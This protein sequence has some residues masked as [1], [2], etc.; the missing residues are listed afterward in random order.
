MQ[1][2]F[3]MSQLNASQATTPLQHPMTSTS[4]RL[5]PMAAAQKQFTPGA[6]ITLS[7]LLRQNPGMLSQRRRRASA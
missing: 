2:S 6:G 7:N 1:Q 5:N 4:L 3:I